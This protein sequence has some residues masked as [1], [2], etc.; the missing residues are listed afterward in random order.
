MTKVIDGNIWFLSPY[1][2]KLKVDSYMSVTQIFRLFW[3]VKS[4]FYYK[5]VLKIC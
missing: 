4:K 1:L 3:S 2:D 5:N